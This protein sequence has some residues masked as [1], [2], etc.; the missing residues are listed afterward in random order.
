M[1]FG[2]SST[3][4]DQVPFP[5][6]GTRGLALAVDAAANLQSQQQEQ[7]GNRTQTG[8]PVPGSPKRAVHFHWHQ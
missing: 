1:G 5:G 4:Q 7:L 2:R 6:R 8:S 3:T